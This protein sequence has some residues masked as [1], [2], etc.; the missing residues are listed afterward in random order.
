MHFVYYIIMKFFIF[1][2][3]GFIVKKTTTSAYSEV[4]I[5]CFGIIPTMCL[6]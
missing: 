5:A 6:I 4:I 3:A 1:G 2:S